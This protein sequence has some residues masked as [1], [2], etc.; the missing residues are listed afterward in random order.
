MT[1]G[2]LLALEYDDF[3]ALLASNPEMHDLINEVVEKRKW[4]TDEQFLDLMGAANLIPGPNSTE[5]GCPSA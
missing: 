3:R 2:V 1:G 4:V 5:S